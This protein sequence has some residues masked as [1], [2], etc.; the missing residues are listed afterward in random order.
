MPDATRFELVDGQLVERNM[1]AQSSWVGGKLVHLLWSHCESRASGDVF[2]ADCSY[3]CFPAEPD[4]VRRPDGSFIRRGRMSKEQ[5]EHGHV[6]IAPDLAIEV[7]SPN[8]LAYEVDEKVEEYLQAGVRLVWVVNPE[9]RIVE[10]HRPDGSVTKLRE[11]ETLSGEDVIADFSCAIRD[12][13]PPATQ[14]K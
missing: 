4:K 6:R 10:V 14:A 8:D 12:L 5:F 1:S 13:F 2:Q 3:Q 7:V 11:H 9:T